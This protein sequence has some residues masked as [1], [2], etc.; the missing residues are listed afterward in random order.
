MVYALLKIEREKRHLKKNKEQIEKVRQAKSSFKASSR[1]EEK[2]RNFERIT[3]GVRTAWMG[4]IGL[5]VI[6][7]V[8]SGGESH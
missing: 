8:S 7:E 6:S 1:R 3:G 5:I 2:I 4:V